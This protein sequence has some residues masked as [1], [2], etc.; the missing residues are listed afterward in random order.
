MR[1]VDRPQRAAEAGWRGCWG[2]RV[3]RYVGSWQRPRG[4]T[5]SPQSVRVWWSRTV[6]DVVRPWVAR[7]GARL[8]G[9]A[10]LIEPVAGALRDEVRAP[11]PGGDASARGRHPCKQLLPI[12]GCEE[13]HQATGTAHA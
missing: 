2:V 7:I 13:E 12:Q 4:A 3:W 8:P 6:L 9:G 10:R 11:H 1:C 5:Q